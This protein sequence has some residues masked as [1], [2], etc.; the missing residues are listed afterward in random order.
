MFSPITRSQGGN[1]ISATKATIET[2]VAETAIR[3]IPG[4]HLRILQPD[5]ITQ[6]KQC[7]S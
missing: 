5:S 7:Q 3:I 4:R 6:W 1:I 2:H